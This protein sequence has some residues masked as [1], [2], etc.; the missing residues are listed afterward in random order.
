[1]ICWCTGTVLLDVEPISATPT[2]AVK[3]GAVKVG[4]V[5]KAGSDDEDDWDD[6]D[7]SWGDEGAVL[8]GAAKTEARFDSLTKSV[9]A[10]T[11]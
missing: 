11:I 1:M 8:D 6:E 5:E 4:V 3:I 2:G 7:I 9:L 10:S